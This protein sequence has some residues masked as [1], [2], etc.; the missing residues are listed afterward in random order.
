MGKKKKQIRFGVIDSETDPFAYGA[1][2]LPFI[3]GFYDGDEYKEFRKTDD[4]VDFLND[5]SLIVYA[6]NGGKFD[7]HFLID[8]IEPYSNL[9]IING[10][11]SKMN[12]GACELRDSYNILPVPLSAFKKDD[13]DYSLMERKNRIKPGNMTKISKYLRNDCLYL[14]ELIRRFHDE[15]GMN[16]TQAGSSL[17]QWKKISGLKVPNSS[18]EFYD[19]IS[20]FYYGGRVECFEK[21]V[22]ERP[23][24]VYDIN[25]AYPYAMLSKHPYSL[26]YDIKSGYSKNA[27]FL[28]VECVSRGAFPF[29]GANGLAFPSDDERRIYHVS[30][31]EFNIAIETKTIKDINVIESLIFMEHTDF[32]AYINHFYEKR[33]KAKIA[34]DEAGSLLYKL[35]MNSLYGKFASN[36]VNYREYMAIPPEAIESCTDLGWNFCGEFGNEFLLVDSPLSTEKMTFYNVATG[37][38]I[39][40]YVRAMLWRAICASGGILYCDTDSIACSDF[41]ELHRMGDELGQWK[42]EGDFTRAGI[43]GKKLYIFEGAEGTKKASKGA[44]LKDSELWKVAAGETVEYFNNAPTFSYNKEVSYIKRNIKIT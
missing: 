16:L 40:G 23:F 4:I 37:A 17:K 7:F 14:Y 32:S 24:S 13:F 1:E 28:T 43:A 31:W 2:I 15:Y 22:I 20:P 19:E 34:K 44:R 18:A 42:H 30:K 8:Y 27:D 29:R 26:N 41:G 11:I 39:T 10:R 33:K 3:W 38:S 5:Q 35:A 21:G 12:L 9:M 6:H 36:P 25:S